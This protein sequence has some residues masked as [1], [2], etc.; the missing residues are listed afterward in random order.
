[1]NTYPTKDTYLGTYLHTYDSDI[2]LPQEH[3]QKQYDASKDKYE[4]NGTKVW[5]VFE[6]P[7]IFIKRS[8]NDGDPLNLAISIG[9]KWKVSGR[10]FYIKRHF[11]APD[12]RKRYGKR[13][14]TPKKKRGKFIIGQAK[15]L[16][17]YIEKEGKT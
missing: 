14:N 11:K 5:C 10:A 4:R 1:M 2:I 9:F 6:K 13:K 15:R 12:E 16:K 3:L 17:N 8:N 7:Q